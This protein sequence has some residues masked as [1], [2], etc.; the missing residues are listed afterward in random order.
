MHGH[1]A[2]VCGPKHGGHSKGFFFG[3]HSDWLKLPG[4]LAAWSPLLLVVWEHACLTC[5]P[6]TPPAS[7]SSALGCLT[8]KQLSCRSGAVHP[9]GICLVH[10]S[11]MREMIG[12]FLDSVQNLTLTTNQFVQSV[13]KLTLTTSV[14]G[15]SVKGHIGYFFVTT[16][17]KLRT[18]ISISKLQILTLY[19]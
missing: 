17:I 3:A 6:H 9:D 10:R 16:C 5:S 14:S 15:L 19:L 18:L 2:V 1:Y 12:L 7:A 13:K 8:I 11:K 4:S